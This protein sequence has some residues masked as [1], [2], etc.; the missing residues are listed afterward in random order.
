LETVLDSHWLELGAENTFCCFS[1]EKERIGV[2]ATARLEAE[3]LEVETAAKDA[4]EA[5]WIA[6]EEA[7]TTEFS[8]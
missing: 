1:P 3:A 2:A 8:L 4:T 5:D 7:M 6:R